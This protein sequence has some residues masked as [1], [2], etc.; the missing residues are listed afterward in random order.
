MPQ[1]TCH[2][3]GG[4]KWTSLYEELLKKGHTEESAAR[5]ANS[6][7]AKGDARE[8]AAERAIL[9]NRWRIRLGLE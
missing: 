2:H 9:S 1:P 6:V 4:E 7:M 5:I 3:P 8:D